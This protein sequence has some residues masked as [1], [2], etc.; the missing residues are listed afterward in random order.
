MNTNE[1]KKLTTD[2]YRLIQMGIFVETHEYAA[3]A[4]NVVETHGRAS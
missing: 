4:V 3:L 2:G 1:E